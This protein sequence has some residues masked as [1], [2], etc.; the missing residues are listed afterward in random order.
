MKT[1]CELGLVRMYYKE[2]VQWLDSKEGCNCFLSQARKLIGSYSRNPNTLQ[3]QCRLAARKAIGG[4]HF[5][6]RVQ[7]LQVPTSVKNY[8]IAL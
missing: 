2:I 8:I 3:A 7:T 1:M 4:V 5:V 6:S